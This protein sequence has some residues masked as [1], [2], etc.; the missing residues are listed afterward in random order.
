MV[1]E[2]GLEWRGR[3]GGEGGRGSG[4]MEKWGGSGQCQQ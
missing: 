3:M 1:E 2:E 4:D